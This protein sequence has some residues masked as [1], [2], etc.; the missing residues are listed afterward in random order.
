MTT[1]TLLFP[2]FTTHNR[3]RIEGHN[4]ERPPSW[5]L[6]SRVSDFAQYDE[7]FF[8][9]ISQSVPNTDFRHFQ[10]TTSLSITLRASHFRFSEPFG[11]SL[12]DLLVSVRTFAFRLVV[13]CT[14]VV[15]RVVEGAIPSPDG[16]PPS[17]VVKMPVKT[18]EWLVLITSATMESNWI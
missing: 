7:T 12:G 16:P 2:P 15:C 3:T 4:P 5:F 1:L 11:A 14:I 18:H 13:F 17:L 10:R 9:L 8:V 6:C